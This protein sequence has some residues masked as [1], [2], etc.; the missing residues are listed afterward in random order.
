MCIYIHAAFM[1]V[2]SVYQDWI[3]MTVIMWV[4][5]SLCVCVSVWFHVTF[6][7]PVC[8]RRMWDFM[9]TRSVR[10]T[11]LFPLS[12]FTY[13]NKEHFLALPGC[14][15]P[16]PPSPQPTNPP[17][18][19]AS[20]VWYLS[21]WVCYLQFEKAKEQQEREGRQMTEDELEEWKALKE[22][23]RSYL[24]NAKKV[25]EVKITS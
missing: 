17:L 11:N 4:I 6:V 18:L 21:G 12:L 5:D 7:K 8:Q 3:R 13:C 20:Q 2:Y 16:C 15:A 1:N 19:S 14:H 9:Q 23:A 25:I 22:A 10:V 24:T